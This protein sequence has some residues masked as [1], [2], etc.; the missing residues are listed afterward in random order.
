MIAGNVV[1]GLTMGNLKKAK[2]IFK[3]LQ[4]FSSLSCCVISTW[5]PMQLNEININCRL[6]AK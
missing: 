4:S 3:M 6:M 5:K 1:F 2:T